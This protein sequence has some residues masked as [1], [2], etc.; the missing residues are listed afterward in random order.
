MPSRTIRTVT[1]WFFVRLLAWRT[2]RIVRPS[3]VKVVVSMSASSPKAMLRIPESRQGPRRDSATPFEE[4]THRVVRGG[5]LAELV[6][7]NERDTTEHAKGHRSL[8]RAVEDI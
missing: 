6:P 4:R 5:R 3:S 7:A 8:T 2:G 1:P